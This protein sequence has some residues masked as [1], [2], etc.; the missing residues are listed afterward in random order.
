[1]VL[2]GFIIQVSLIKDMG[3]AYCQIMNSPSKHDFLIDVIDYNEPNFPNLDF[4]QTKESII[5][6][7][8]MLSSFRFDAHPNIQI[9]GLTNQSV[10]KY[11]NYSFRS[12]GEGNYSLGKPERF[13]WYNWYVGID[14]KSLKVPYRRCKHL[15]L[16]DYF[17]LD[18]L[19]IFLSME[20]AKRKGYDLGS[21]FPETEVRK[22]SGWRWALNR[23]RFNTPDLRKI[24]KIYQGKILPENVELE[25]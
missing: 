8:F 9:L 11:E 12:C 25:L 21:L 16:E 1:M 23:V 5:N 15:G 19:I 6:P 13:E 22:N 7:L 17:S 20:W 24:P 3:Y 4:L 14:G 10:D 18:D 2:T